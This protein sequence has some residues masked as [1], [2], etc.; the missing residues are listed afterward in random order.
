MA[1]LT[2]PIGEA[3]M[4]GNDS[5]FANGPY[6]GRKLGEAWAEMPVE[7]R[8]TS[9]SRSGVFPILTKFIF[10]EEKLSVQVHPDD[11]YASKHET[12]AGGVGKT[13]MWYALRARPGA[14]VLAGLKP[15]VTRDKFE[16]RIADGTAE[17]CLEH[18]PLNEGEAIFIPARTAHTIGPGLVLCEIQQHSDLTYRVFDYNRRDANGRTREL[19]IDK[20]LA[21]MRFGPQIC[22]KLQPARFEYAGAREAFFIA[23]SY[24]ATEQ[25]DFDSVISRATSPDRFEVL[26]ILKGSGRIV[27]REGEA[28]YG[29]AQAWLFPA[30]L[31]TYELN[32]ASYTSLLRTY[33]PGNSMDFDEYFA[34][35]GVSRQDW[36]R[37]IR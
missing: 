20:A 29:P 3:W 6:A 13:E 36:A 24:F 23:C 25:W 17:D 37:L 21:V 1:Q 30:A 28:E 2:Q 18:V 31:G 12:A 4:T 7:W 5:V 8:G 11:E 27:W 19:H 14:E 16:Q 32:P 22:C 26:I 35:R 15:E 33:V 10:A 9:V 34:E